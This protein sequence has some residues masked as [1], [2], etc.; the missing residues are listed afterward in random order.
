MV[1]KGQ[2]WLLHGRTTAN[3]NQRQRLLSNRH[4]Y[5]NCRW[6]PLQMRACR[7][8]LRTGRESGC[9]SISP[10]QHWSEGFVP[11]A[12][13]CLPIIYGGPTRQDP[14]FRIVIHQDLQS[15][16]QKKVK[17]RQSSS[18]LNMDMT[19]QDQT[20]QIWH[21]KDNQ[22]EKLVWT[23]RLIVGTPRLEMTVLLRITTNYLV[24]YFVKQDEAFGWRDFITCIDNNNWWHLN[25]AIYG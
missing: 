21:I 14:E 17:C 24:V 15:N 4:D 12:V 19:F 7:N 2:Y 3:E 1:S 13:F 25:H 10:S 6:L 23:F 18:A 22:S 8:C 11:R 20:F 5:T 16:K 9:Q